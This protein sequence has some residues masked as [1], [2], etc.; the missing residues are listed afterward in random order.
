SPGP[1]LVG[2]VGLGR[3]PQI[4]GRHSTGA[5]GRVHPGRTAHSH[6]GMDSTPPLTRKTPDPERWGGPGVCVSGRWGTA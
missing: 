4:G 6:H 2:R 5:L 1:T 3:V